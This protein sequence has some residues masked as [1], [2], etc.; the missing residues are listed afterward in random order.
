M[1]K[2]WIESTPDL[3]SALPGAPY[4]NTGELLRMVVAARGTDDHGSGGGGSRPSS[5]SSD[6]GSSDSGLLAAPLDSTK[7]PET[8]GKDGHARV[9]PL[10]KGMLPTAQAELLVA[11]RSILESAVSLGQ[12]PAGSEACANVGE[13]H[14]VADPDNGATVR[15]RLCDP[16]LNWALTQEISP[17]ATSGGTDRAKTVRKLKDAQSIVIDHVAELIK[18]S[19]DGG[20]AYGAFV[21][22]PQIV[23]NMLKGMIVGSHPYVTRDKTTRRAHDYGMW[24]CVP[25]ITPRRPMTTLEFWDWYYP[26]GS[27][28]G[29][30]TVAAKRPRQ[31]KL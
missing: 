12:T 9:V 27:Y 10:P 24:M 30:L 31:R 4:T 17:A 23:Q 25:M 19:S 15:K 29:C 20:V 6:C 16:L 21:P 5:S 13:V 3:A 11:R 26:V 22:T 28:S 2:W 14:C 7:L 8:K 1:I 18:E